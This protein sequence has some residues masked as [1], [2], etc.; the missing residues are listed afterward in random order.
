MSFPRSSQYSDTL[1]Q[2]KQDSTKYERNNKGKEKTKYTTSPSFFLFFEDDSG[3]AFLLFCFPFRAVDLVVT[4]FSAVEAGDLLEWAACLLSGR[5]D[6]KGNARG[7]YQ[8]GSSL[9]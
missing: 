3:S 1:P 7:S 4:F 5:G 8:L 6:S 9:T 2:T